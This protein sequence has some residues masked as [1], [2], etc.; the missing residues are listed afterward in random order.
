[1][2][3]KLS[4]YILTHNSEKMLEDVIGPL[5]AIADDLL[6][7]D[8]GSTDST[9][10]IARKFGARFI[11]HPL[12]SFKE[13]RNFAHEACL[14]DWVL[15]LDSDEVVSEAFVKEVL[16]LK[17]NGFTHDAY[18]ITRYWIVQGVQVRSIYPIDSPDD[19]VRL[20]D[21]RKVHF[22]R[23]SSHVHESVEG[24][25][26]KGIISAP[27]YHYTFGCD[28]EIERKLHKYTSLA[29]MDIARNPKS[30]RWYFPLTAH[31]RLFLSPPA[32]W[33]KWYIR[34]Q[35]YKDG[36]IGRKLGKYAFQYTYLKYKYYIRH[37]MH[38]RKGR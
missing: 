23:N 1:M 19:P 35:G 18:A 9:P 11:H 28:D 30:R 24:Y 32:A 6:I 34:H 16:E 4:V 17:K 14:Y 27:V 20:I 7:V 10:N 31:Y 36:K 38:D 5:Q 21:R 26:S 29:A 8:S 2:S 22:G 25:E 33:Y 13:Q 3:E 15:A 37:H 12:V